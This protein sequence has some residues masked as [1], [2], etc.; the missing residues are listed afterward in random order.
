MA[1]GRNFPGCVPT[2]ARLLWRAGGADTHGH[3]P[4]H[5][6]VGR[7]AR[8]GPRRG[9]R[10]RE[11]RHAGG[12]AAASGSE[13]PAGAPAGWAGPRLA[14]VSGRGGPRDVVDPAKKILTGSAEASTAHGLSASD[15]AAPR[16]T[17][18]MNF[19]DRSGQRRKRLVEGGPR[20]R[21]RRNY[22]LL[23]SSVRLLTARLAT[24]SPG[25]R[26]LLPSMLIG[27]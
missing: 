9:R 12:A 13:P 7:A 22:G 11:R 26:Q 18:M 8:A 15:A 1:F 21:L 5:P 17:L 4:L 27:C 14:A 2:T 3:K 25:P 16:D 20:R 24:A 23:R 6:E 19:L 10:S